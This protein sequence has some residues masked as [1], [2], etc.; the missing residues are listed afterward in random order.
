M[1]VN[2]IQ[3]DSV[4][5]KNANNRMHITTPQ[6]LS[7]RTQ[8]PKG[9][10]AKSLVNINFRGSQELI[11]NAN[12]YIP[13]PIADIIKYFIVAFMVSLDSLATTMAQAATAFISMNTYA[14]NRSFV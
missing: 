8:F 11:D 5:Q 2:K 7:S 14:V 13:D 12:R 1:K 4:Q 3:T 9:V 10:D 6:I